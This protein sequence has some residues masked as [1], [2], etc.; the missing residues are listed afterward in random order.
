[1]HISLARKH[2]TVSMKYYNERMATLAKNFPQVYPFDIKL[3]TEFIGN[4]FPVTY[5]TAKRFHEIVKTWVLVV[6]SAGLEGIDSHNPVVSYINL[7]KISSWHKAKRIILEDIKQE[8]NLNEK[9]K[10]A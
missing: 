1:M 9:K 5:I 6:D 4:D 3:E 7:Q 10:E 8:L 2:C